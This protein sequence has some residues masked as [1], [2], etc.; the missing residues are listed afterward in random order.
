MGEMYA[1]NILDKGLVSKIY[2]ELIKLNVQKMSNSIKKWEEDK[3]KYF[4][5]EDKQ[6][7]NR[8][9]KRCSTSLM[10]REIKVKTTMKYYLIPVRMAK[11]NNTRNKGC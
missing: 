7:A 6:M 5:K 9:M 10:T 3:N 4:S 1:N 8:Y 2:K 11:I